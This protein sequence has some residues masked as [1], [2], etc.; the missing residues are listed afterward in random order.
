[1][2]QILG[3]LDGYCAIGELNNIWEQSLLNNRPCGCGK[4]FRECPFWSEVMDDAFGGADQVDARAMLALRDATV[5]GKQLPQMAFRRLRSAG[6]QRQVDEYAGV[7]ETIYR[8]V[9]RVSGCEVIV[10]S[11]KGGGHALVLAEM[12]SVQPR[13]IHL[14]R[15]SRATSHSWS[16]RKRR[17]DVADREEYMEKMNHRTVAMHWNVGHT[18]ASIA[19]LR[20][21]AATVCRY[22]D[23][24]VQPRATIEKIIGDLGLDPVETSPFVSDN[25]VC[26]RGTHSLWGNPDRSNQGVVAIRPDSDWQQQMSGWKK[27]EVSALTL[28]W[29]I[30]YRYL[31]RSVL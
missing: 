24:A 2:L 15:D 20:L 7:L 1:M 19:A 3:S 4:L 25:S 29:L 21:D 10:D 12:A 23:F 5:R 18:F 27:L 26:I 14:V 6:F 11:S 16:R 13:M 28:P 17:T 8:S 9:Q 22:E 30:R 31:G